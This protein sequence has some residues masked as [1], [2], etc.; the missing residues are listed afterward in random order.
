[1]EPNVL[2]MNAMI[3][4]LVVGR[5]SAA[6]HMHRRLVVVDIENIA[7]G[8]VMAPWQARLVQDELRRSMGLNDHD[9]VIIG[10]S[11]VGVLNSWM[12]WEGTQ[13]RIVAQSGPDGADLVLLEVLTT[14]RVAARYDEVVIA[15]G[16][17]IFTDAV[18]ALQAAGAVVTVVA[19]A[20]RCA[21]RLRMA[22]NRTVLL[23]PQVQ[24]V[25]VA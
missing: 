11:H 18:T 12:G 2:F 13:P 3:H 23:A 15:S 6:N 24:I 5:G 16:D 21:K 7:Q 9:Q 17:G 14:E 22:A 20:N 1:M 4:T 8:G 10:V 25:G 19:W